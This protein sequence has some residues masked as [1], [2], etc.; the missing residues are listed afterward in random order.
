MT[1]PAS[2]V[3]TILFTDLVN[4]T[5]LL[6]RAGDE[7]AQR[8]FRTHHDLLADTA[9]AHGGEEVK[10]L[11]DG[12]MVAFS[13]AANAVRA[14]VAMQQASRRPVRGER[15][16]IRVGLNAGEAI[17][18]AADWFGLPVVIARR[19]CDGAGGGEIRCTEVVTSLL[20][21]RPEFAFTELG[22]LDLKGVAKPVGA[23]SVEYRTV[24]ATG[25]R[26]GPSTWGETASSTGSPAASPTRPAVPAGSCSGRRRGHRQDPP[27]RGAGGAGRRPEGLGAVG[28]L[29]RR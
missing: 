8:V 4:S 29:L 16:T 11:G 14:A 23:Y 3:V 2:A 5:D 28:P 13:S 7:E 26:P 27:R 21:G 9:A 6:S 19:L 22:P 25:L 24:P 12:L 1:E 20:T 18:D 10:W 15:L 17:R